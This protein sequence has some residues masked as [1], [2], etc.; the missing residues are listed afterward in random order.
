MAKR[1]KICKSYDAL[2]FNNLL[3]AKIVSEKLKEK[4]WFKIFEETVIE[5]FK[6]GH[7]YKIT[8]VQKKTKFDFAWIVAPSPEQA[9]KINIY[10]ISLD[11]EILDAKFTI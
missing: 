5:G 4:E 2:T 1:G 3:S 9:K 7:E 8:N 6:R 11:N 10:K